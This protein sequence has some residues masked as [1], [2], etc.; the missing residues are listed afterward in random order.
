MQLK[1]FDDAGLS[2]TFAAQTVNH[3]L[4]IC[5]RMLCA[6]NF[7]FFSFQV[8]LVWHVY[9]FFLFESFPFFVVKLFDM[10]TILIQK[11]ILLAFLNSQLC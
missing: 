4:L 3:S 1:H 7:F 2:G 9:D 10:N 6:E 11:V 8:L 5:N